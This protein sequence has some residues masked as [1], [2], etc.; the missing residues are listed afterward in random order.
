MLIL[1]PIE[2]SAQSPR[3]RQLTNTEES[4]CSHYAIVGE[5]VQPGCY[6]LQHPRW[7][8]HDVTLNDLLS[9]SKGLTSH[10]G[11]QVAIVRHGRQ[12]LCASLPLARNDTLF[13]G[14]I[15]VVPRAHDAS[16]STS[17][18][19]WIVLT[20]LA[21]YPVVT[22]VVDGP[23]SL[24][25]LLLYL[26]QPLSLAAHVRVM[27]PF[28]RV[29]NNPRQP[30]NMLV[31]GS[32]VVLPTGSIRAQTLPPLPPPRPW[33]SPN[34]GQAPAPESMVSQAEIQHTNTLLPPST[35]PLTPQSGNE[36]YLSHPTDPEQS[37]SAPPPPS[38]PTI[39]IPS[40]NSNHASK[41]KKL[42]DIR[43]DPPYMDPVL[44]D[45]GSSEAPRG[46]LPPSESPLF[47]TSDLLG[48]EDSEGETS[49]VQQL[50][51]SYPMVA[52]SLAIMLMAWGMLKGGAKRQS[53]LRHRLTFF[54][55]TRFA[56]YVSRMLKNISSVTKLLIS[57]VRVLMKPKS[58][59][60]TLPSVSQNMSNDVVIS[61]THP[62]HTWTTTRKESHHPDGVEQPVGEAALK[63]LITHGSP[64]TR[65]MAA[66]TWMHSATC[67]VR[68]RHES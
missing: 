42:Q 31:H 33:S 45:L 35:F 68:H 34:V 28:S 11:S 25:K 32:V 29:S 6:E 40:R 20:G 9:V 26:G 12:I 41:I 43:S 2:G 39:D 23:L 14:D 60:H 58:E 50:T 1:G 56:S 63:A 67:H 48:D 18:S 59:D 36:N 16:L 64:V 51:A 22:E 53:S 17:S 19:C 55:L 15:V 61:S 7:S 65:A 47:E 21:T 38:D 62:S 5:I 30:Q 54:H 10:A 52:M 3:I 4:T 66:I 57:N 13:D 8:A 46:Y 27:T 37:S 49:V 24:D 44:K